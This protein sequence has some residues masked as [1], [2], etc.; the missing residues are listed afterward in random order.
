MKRFPLFVALVSLAPLPFGGRASAQ[1]MTVDIDA[2]LNGITSPK[3]VALTAG[4][5]R[6]EPIQGAHTAWHASSGINQGCNAAGTNCVQGWSTGFLLHMGGSRTGAG[7]GPDAFYSTAS[8]ALASS[9]SLDFVLPTAASIGLSVTDAFLLDNLGG[10]TLQLTRLSDPVAAS[11]VVR[12]GTPPN[13][14]AFLPGVTSA[15]VIGQ[16]WDPIID[17]TSFAPSSLIDFIGIDVN[18]PINTTLTIGTLLCQLPPPKQIYFTMPGTS[19]QVPI[20][21]DCSLAGQT[22]CSQAGSLSSGPQLELTN[23]IDFVIGNL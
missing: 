15:P 22:Y 4:C 6:V 7:N 3:G 10:L 13:P 16:V 9:T 1:Q 20:P 23:A 21:N 18:G 12:L 11:E 5:W 17:H 8:Q 19:F 14:N 2:A